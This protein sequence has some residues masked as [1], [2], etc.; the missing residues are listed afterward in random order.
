MVIYLCAGTSTNA[1]LSL[2]PYMSMVIPTDMFLLSQVVNAPPGLFT[3]FLMMTYSDKPIIVAVD[4]VQLNVTWDNN[5]FMDWKYSWVEI[6]I[7]EGSHYIEQLADENIWA[8]TYSIYGNMMN[9]SQI[10]GN[11]SLSFF[12]IHSDCSCGLISTNY[13]TTSSVFT[14]SKTSISKPISNVTST[15]V[16]GDQ[17]DIHLV[18]TPLSWWDALHY[19]RHNY[20]DLLSIPNSKT[21]ELAARVSRNITAQGLWIGLRRHQVWG[22]L[23]W[24]DGEAVS[25]INWGDGEPSDPV[26]D[27]CTIMSQTNNFTWNDACCDTKFGF[28]CY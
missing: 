27:M 18:M 26:S 4:G 1:N 19:C 24:T 7:N 12:G 21:Q 6:S 5:V 13:I 14:T 16:P 22:Y 23:Y 8:M 3:R 10:A 15:T 2:K 17:D 11:N 25:Y 20:S 9:S 28:I